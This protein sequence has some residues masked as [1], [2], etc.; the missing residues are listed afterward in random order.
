MS[1][2]ETRGFDAVSVEEI[3]RAAGIGRATFFRLFG[4]KAGLIEEANRRTAELVS[5]R[6]GR[7]S[8]RGPQALGLMGATIAEAWLGAGAPVHAMF[9]SFVDRAHA[10]SGYGEPAVDATRTGSRALAH[11]AVGYVAEGQADGDFRED[12]DPEAMGIGFMSLIIIACSAWLGRDPR[13]GPAFE[14]RIEE[15]VGVMVR[16]MGRLPA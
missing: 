3:C 16:G 5:F 12:L 11:L 13:S 15:A 7:A 6:V 1:L 10:M 4:G 2:F 9:E 14:R 8:A